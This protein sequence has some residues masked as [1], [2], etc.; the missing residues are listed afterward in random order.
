MPWI[1]L[2]IQFQFNYNLGSYLSTCDLMKTKSKLEAWH[3]CSSSFE[4][5]GT[6]EFGSSLGPT[7]RETKGHNFLSHNNK[8]RTLYFF[9]NK[10]GIVQKRNELKWIPFIFDMFLCFALLWWFINWMYAC[11]CR[12][13]KERLLRLGNNPP[14]SIWKSVSC[15]YHGLLFTLNDQKMCSVG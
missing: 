11:M 12:D 2:I 14:M 13:V 7:C 8:I 3:T 1:N 4:L 6:I 5:L 15:V 9:Q 10:N